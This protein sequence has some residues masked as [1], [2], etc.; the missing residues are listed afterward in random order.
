MKN[1]REIELA[2][3]LDK[4]I[5]TYETKNQPYAL[6]N[7][8][9]NRFSLAYSTIEPTGNSIEIIEE[10]KGDLCF[11]CSEPISDPL[12]STEVRSVNQKSL[13]L[14]VGKEVYIYSYLRDKKTL[15]KLKTFPK[16]DISAGSVYCCSKWNEIEDG[17]LLAGSSDGSVT[18]IDVNLG[19]KISQII[20]DDKEIFTLDYSAQHPSIFATGSGVGRLR[21]F[22]LRDKESFTTVYDFQDTKSSSTPIVKI[23]NNNVEPNLFAFCSD[24][25]SSVFVVD[26][27]KPKQLV[28]ELNSN[29]SAATNSVAWKPKSRNA[30]M[31]ADSEGR[32]LIWD[33]DKSTSNYKG[34]MFEYSTRDEVLNAIWEEPFVNWISVAIAGNRIEVLGF[35][36]VL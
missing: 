19:E 30:L 21:L 18:Q 7:F 32:V 3:P 6:S 24:G 26:V 16:S 11:V 4:S 31:S 28:C 13:L 29:E 9:S 33:A 14:A 2:N 36:D 8:Y 25:K 27:R 34:L 20:C 1:S 10:F 17:N 5:L 15:V 22:D 35:K 12:L 23:D